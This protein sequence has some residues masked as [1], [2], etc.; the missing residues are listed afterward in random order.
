MISEKRFFS[1][2]IEC[3]KAFRLVFVSHSSK[4]PERTERG[5]GDPC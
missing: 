4:V 3:L 5:V 1:F 2:K